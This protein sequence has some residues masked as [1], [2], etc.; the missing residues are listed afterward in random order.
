MALAGA[1]CQ[2]V[3]LILDL[4]QV[5]QDRA[6]VLPVQRQQINHAVA[7][8]HD[9]IALAVGHDAVADL[10]GKIQAAGRGLR[11]GQ[12][13]QQVGHGR[14]AFQRPPDGQELPAGGAVHVFMHQPGEACNLAQQHAHRQRS[15]VARRHG[16]GHAAHRLFQVLQR[17][18]AIDRKAVADAAGRPHGMA[19]RPDQAGGQ[20]LGGVKA[21][22]FEVLRDDFA[23]RVGPRRGQA[24][25]VG[26]GQAQQPF[27]AFH[28]AAQPVQ[29]V[30]R[31]AG[32]GAGFCP[33]KGAAG[34]G[35]HGIIGHRRVRHDP[36]IRHRA[37]LPH[38]DGGGI[39]RGADPGKTAR[40]CLPALRRAGQKHPDRHRP[41]NQPAVLPDR[42]GGQVDQFL[43]DQPRALRDQ[44]VVKRAC[45]PAQL[46][47]QCMSVVRL[48]RQA[49]GQGGADQHFCRMGADM[50]ALGLLAAP[51][52]GDVGQ[53]QG[54]SVQRL[55]DARQ[56]GQHGL[57]FQHAHPQRVHQRHGS[58]TDRGQQA[59]RADAAGLVQFQRIGPMRVQPAPEHVD[60]HRA[61]DGAHLDRVILDRQIA[62]FQQA[63]AQ[64][65]GDIGMLVI[66]VGHRAGGQ[67][68]HLAA[69]PH[70][71]IALQPVQRIAK[72]AE[73]PGQAVHIALAIDLGKDPA[74][75]DA[76]FQGKARA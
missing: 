15:I 32:Q 58:G 39:G 69:R 63:Q 23:Q 75:G 52:G 71:G 14:G 40:H 73:K 53:F 62:A 38:R 2:P 27:A 26:A 60:R 13:R 7:A 74:C 70:R 9:G 47:G 24:G 18:P 35:Q 28:I 64:I 65:A 56:K 22:A 76:V 46:A 50:I 67:D 20:R 3:R 29:I 6:R 72:G 10:E 59:G 51:P 48:K 54:P 36:D 49:G 5:K 30:G 1:P 19:Q 12:Q 44:P 33:G 25:I 68:A 43:P 34:F 61:G 66:G 55:G 37:A 57:A 8:G 42:R 17:G 16:A 11:I 45:G 4:G 31:P 21:V 41:R